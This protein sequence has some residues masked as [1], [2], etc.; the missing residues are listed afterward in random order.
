MKKIS[1]IVIAFLLLATPYMATYA[2]TW[3][4]SRPTFDPGQNVLRNSKL[5]DTDPIVLVASII[6][7]LLTILGLIA[8]VLIVYGGFIWM[9]SRGNE[10]E[11]TKAKN[12]IQGAIIGL[13]VILASYGIAGY[14]FTTVL[15][16]TGA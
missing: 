7:W 10:E 6:N 9:M 3:N 13:I 11:T 15:E 14:V 4:P 16:M 12:I 5:G 2:G 8:L 1:L